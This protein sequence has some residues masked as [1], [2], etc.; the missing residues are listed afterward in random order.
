MNK[1]TY[2]NDVEF[3]K[4]YSCL[5][6]NAR[7]KFLEHLSTI[8]PVKEDTDDLINY[9]YCTNYCDNVYRSGYKYVYIYSTETGIPFYVGYG[10]KNRCTNISSRNSNFIENISNL[11]T[12]RIFG[13]VSHLNEK[14]ALEV[15]TLCIW[16][17]LSRGFKLVNKSKIVVDNIKHRE[18]RLHYPEIVESIDKITSDV[19]ST[20]LEDY[21]VFSKNGL[22]EKN[23]VSA[24]K[25][26]S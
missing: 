2:Y 17:L 16:E 11:D 1:V 9:E 22:V 24:I 6:D 13:I 26:V 21:D 15:E 8:P 3:D 19:I 5:G 4:W 18:L 14:E 7:I 20:I 12:F 25:R 23:G 10:D